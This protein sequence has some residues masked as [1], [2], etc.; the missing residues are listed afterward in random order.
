MKHDHIRYS[1]MYD[2]RLE[3]ACSN[4]NKQNWE[5]SI[6]K[7]ITSLTIYIYNK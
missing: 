3:T 2:S 7:Y 1:Y 6:E 5:K 4:Y